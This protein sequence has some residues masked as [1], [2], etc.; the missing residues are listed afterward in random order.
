MGAI[1]NSHWNNPPGVSPKLICNFLRHSKIRY[2]PNMI[3]RMATDVSPYKT[4]W[5]S[6]GTGLV[7]VRTQLIKP[8][9]DPIPVTIKPFDCFRLIFCLANSLRYAAIVSSPNPWDLSFCS[10]ESAS[11]FSRIHFR[12]TEEEIK[13]FSVITKFLKHNNH[14]CRYKLQLHLK[15]K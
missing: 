4:T 13:W 9:T 6:S 10:M 7:R 2:K 14:T 15:T 1:T 12:T 5:N 8:S 3:S 11:K